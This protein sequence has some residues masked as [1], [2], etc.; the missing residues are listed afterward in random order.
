[1][2][3]IPTGTILGAPVFLARDPYGDLT[4]WRGEPGDD[5]PLA[6][7]DERTSEPLV[8]ALLLQACF[9]ITPK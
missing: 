1:M 8:W 2:A 9:S 5:Y 4:I 6:L 7:A 3:T